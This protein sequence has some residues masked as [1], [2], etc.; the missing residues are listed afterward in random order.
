MHRFGKRLMYA[1]PLI[2]AFAVAAACGGDDNTAVP[3]GT[4]SDA[5]FGGAGGSG[6]TGTMIAAVTIVPGA[7]GRGLGAYSPN[8]A[9][10][11][12]GT[13]V[14]W[15]NT[16]SIAHTVTSTSGLWDS[17]AIAPGGTFSRMFNQTGTFPYFCTIHGAAAMSGSVVVQ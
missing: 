1:F 16:D 11:A 15:T 2:C 5:G 9:V 12:I 8:P 17:G 10:V 7:N 14:T 13:T 3:P 6:A 4:I